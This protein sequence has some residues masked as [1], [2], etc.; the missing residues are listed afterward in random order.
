MALAM[1][2]VRPA[3]IRRMGCQDGKFF[4]LGKTVLSGT[5]RKGKIP[6]ILDPGS[7]IQMDKDHLPLQEDQNPLR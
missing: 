7:G 6:S 2:Q 3:D 4:I 1:C 5:V